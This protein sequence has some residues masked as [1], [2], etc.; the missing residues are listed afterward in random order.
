ML[1]R[2]E[3]IAALA[4]LIDGLPQLQP[5]PSNALALMLAETVDRL[6]RQIVGNAP[7]DGAMIL[8]RANAAAATIG[9]EAQQARLRVHPDDLGFFTDAE[10]PVPIVG[11]ATLARGSVRLDT[12]TGW[13]E[14]GH[15]VRLDYLRVALDNLAVPQ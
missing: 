2:S 3:D 6:V 9:E 7:V 1:F 14:D 5:E 8:S 11:D 10:L 15:D 4:G 13:I 12:A